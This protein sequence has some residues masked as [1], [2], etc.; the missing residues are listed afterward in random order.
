MF[1]WKSLALQ[2]VSYPHKKYEYVLLFIVYSICH[3]KKW[4]FQG[5]FNSEHSFPIFRLYSVN[6]ILYLKKEC[7]KGNMT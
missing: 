5:L 7:N 4:N 1:S 2:I 3:A 6:G